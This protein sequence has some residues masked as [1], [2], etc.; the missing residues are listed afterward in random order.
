M[1]EW[2]GFAH[3]GLPCPEDKSTTVGSPQCSGTGQ[4]L[5]VHQSPPASSHCLPITSLITLYFTK[6]AA[7][8]LH[9]ESTEL[10][11]QRLGE[12]RLHSL[13]Q[14]PLLVRSIAGPHASALHDKFP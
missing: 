11:H 4:D 8:Y 3:G 14:F 9:V 5:E 1:Q 2:K 12:G 13:Q 10:F 7:S 6:Y